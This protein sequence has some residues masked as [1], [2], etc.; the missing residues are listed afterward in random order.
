MI[1][2]H[3]MEHFT[4]EPQAIPNRLLILVDRYLSVLLSNVVVLVS[5]EFFI[6]NLGLVILGVLLQ[7]SFEA[8]LR[9]LS[10]RVCSVVDRVL[11]K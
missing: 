5:L 8:L 7:N 6:F 2:H 9:R 1:E 4:S 11:L 3:H 10:Y